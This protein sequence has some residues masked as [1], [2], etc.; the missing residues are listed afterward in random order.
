D[1][2]VMARDDHRGD[3]HRLVRR[4]D[5]GL[6]LRADVDGADAEDTAEEA[7]LVLLRRDGDRV[8]GAVRRRDRHVGTEHAAAV[9]VGVADRH[10][11]RGPGR[12]RESLC[13]GERGCVRRCLQ[14][15]LFVEPGAHVEHE[16]PHSE[17]RGQ[18]DDGQ[19]D[20][21][22]PF[23]A[24]PTHSTR[25][26][27]V[28]WRFPLFTTQPMR[29]IEYGYWTSTVT[30]EPGP[31]DEEHETCNCVWSRSAAEERTMLVQSP[32]GFPD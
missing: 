12:I 16:R 9:L 25:S 30:S 7:G 19:D 2:R 8:V 14:L 1:Q 11:L 23:V 32:T 29:L 21:L 6:G 5:E 27:T 18:R 17:Q 31:H 24:R 26:L 3:V 15:P 28:V 4:T 22:T 13:A 10:R 20:D